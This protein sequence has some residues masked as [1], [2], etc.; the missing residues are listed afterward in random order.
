MIL[1]R[2]RI[3]ALI[4]IL[5]FP[6][7]LRAQDTLRPFPGAS[8]IMNEV[9]R[10]C[11][12][13]HRQLWGSYLW[14]P[15]VFIDRATRRVTASEPDNQGILH[16]VDSLYTG[17][18]PPDRIIANFTTEL[19]GKK[20]TMVAWPLPDDVF[21]RDVLVIHELFHYIQP[22]IGHAPPGGISYDNRHM[23]D[24]MARVFL[25]MEWRALEIAVNAHPAEK[26]QPLEDALVFRN[27]RRMLYPGSDTMENLFE[28]H[29]GLAEY[30]GYRLCSM[31]NEDF[32]KHINENHD[33]Y[34]NT[35]SYVRSFAYYS[36]I[37]YGY[38]LDQSD[39][40]WRY[41]MEPGDDLGWMTSVAFNLDVPED[42]PSA[43]ELIKNDY[44]YL[45]VYN[46]ELERKNE[47]D[48]IT[49]LNH[50]IFLE[51]SVLVLPLENP[52]IGFNPSNLQPLGT[53]GTVYPN[54]EIVD[55]WGRLSV[56]RGGCLLSNDWREA[57]I[58]ATGM[59]NHPGTATGPGWNLVLNEGY[60]IV[61]ER[62]NFRI[63]RK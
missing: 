25:K 29:E 30:T 40:N 59:T 13:D 39:V 55:S 42:I 52:R 3:A 32:K 33:V 9:H 4:I 44:G 28:C 54:I 5:Q 27:Y 26:Y 63:I 57:R 24:M 58:T 22:A 62:N 50:E 20:F 12:N 47:K 2:I 37:L 23:D 15:V 49:K 16:F 1:F 51:Q 35:A 48:R 11:D 17:L 14:N 18:F 46:A 38:L 21:T 53:E 19:G 56:T 61:P 10:I 8:R 36:G 41:H 31:S 45:Q 34:W 6:V 43:V 60:E 7:F